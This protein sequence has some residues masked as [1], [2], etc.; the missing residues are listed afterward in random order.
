MYPSH[1][2]S[3]HGACPA[4][5][6]PRVLSRPPHP[7]H[8]HARCSFASTSSST[9]IRA[10][11]P[12]VH[13]TSHPV[14]AR[15][16]ESEGTSYRRLQ[17]TFFRCQRRAAS[18]ASRVATGF[19]TWLAPFAPRWSAPF[20]GEHTPLRR[21]SSSCSASV[22]FSL[23]HHEAV[24]LTPRHFPGH[25]GL[26]RPFLRLRR[27]RFHRASVFDARLS[28]AR[29]PSTDRLSPRGERARTRVT[30]TRP[31]SRAPRA[32]HAQS[33]APW[34]LPLRARR[35]RSSMTFP[36][37]CLL[38]QASPASFCSL[39]S[40]P[41]ATSAES[42]RPSPSLA[43]VEAKRI[44]E[45]TARAGRRHSRLRAFAPQS[46]E[47]QTARAPFVTRALDLED[48]EHLRDR[49]SLGSRP[50]SPYRPPRR[51]RHI[52]EPG[53]FPRQPSGTH[54]P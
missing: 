25:P 42:S 51:G 54:A 40:R 43:M 48:G 34:E 2:R 14:K 39:L 15:A 1:A 11:P 30:R 5:S 46:P 21:A 29:T 36:P 8:S 16:S 28:R 53:A 3:A 35:S 50:L 20:H 7:L 22:V 18:F 38:R 44:S 23:P 9:S 52:E 41:A 24:P 12:F 47:Q 13:W 33:R 17:P 31:E 27:A 37:P 26:F 19:V 32:L 10:S 49:P 6:R 45:E 4:I